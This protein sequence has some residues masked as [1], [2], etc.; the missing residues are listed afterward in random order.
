MSK[1]TSKKSSKK[2]SK[3]S[4]KNVKNKEF[5]ADVGKFYDELK[6]ADKEGKIFSFLNRYYIFQK[7]E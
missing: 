5:Y 7:I 1:K 6:G 3:K 4:S 2:T